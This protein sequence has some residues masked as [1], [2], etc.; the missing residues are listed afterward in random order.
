MPKLPFRADHVGSLLRPQ[1]LSNARQKWREGKLETSALKNLEDTHIRDIIS[2]Q[3]DI[4]LKSITDGEFRRDYW[5]LDFISGFKGVSVNQDT[6][7]HTFSGGDTVA[8]FSVTDKIGPH[9]GNMRDHFSFLKDNTKQTAKFCIPG[10]GMTHIRSGRSGISEDAYP[11]LDAYWADLA[12]AYS[13]EIKKLADLGCTYLQIDDVSF[14]Y[15]CDENFRTDIKKRGDN[16]DELL[17]RYSRALSD[18]ISNRP[19]NMTVTTHMCRGNFKSTYMTSGGYDSVAERMFEEL[20][21]DGYF[22]EYDSDRAGGFEPLRYLPKDQMVVLGL[23]TSKSPELE[24]K[25]DIKRRIDE[26]AKFVDLD[27]ICLSP[28]CGFSSTH[29]G[30]NLTQ[31]EERKKLELVVEIAQEVWGSS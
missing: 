18:A 29:H 26:A 24:N 17:V 25:D 20:K 13:A 4:G 12:I 22:M 7:G 6:Y 10:P 28:Q 30:N 19:K 9:S 14:A 21:V 11:D 27:L 16:P 2:F 3:E 1:K 23:I 31:D 5:H 8:T 15:L